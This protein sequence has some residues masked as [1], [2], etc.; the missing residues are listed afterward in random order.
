M[1]YVAFATD[2]DGTLATKGAVPE[3]AVDALE[4]L[5]ASDRHLFLVTGRQLEDLRKVFDRF[6]LFEWVVA[7]NGAVLF[8]PGTNEIRELGSAPPPEFAERLREQGV[9]PL[10]LGEVIVATWEPHQGTVLE[11][12]RELG[13]EL[14]IVFNKGAVMV[15]PPGVN[16][17]TGLHA[18]LEAAGISAH[19]VAG[20]GDAEND[21]AFLDLCECSVAVAN[22]LPSV[23]ERCDHVTEGDHADGVIEIARL[24]ADE[25]LATLEP[26]LRRHDVEL[27]KSDDDV[28]TVPAY[29]ATILLAGPSGSG[30]STLSTGLIERIHDAGYQ[31]CL[32]DPEGDYED[33]PG[34]VVL[35]DPDRVPSEDEV[36][37]VMQD[38]GTS[39]VL[40][41]L[42][43]RLED[44]PSYFDRLIPP[45]QQFR[46]RTG[47]P[48]WLV[49]DEAHHLLPQTRGAAALTLPLDLG[50]A[51]LVTI[52]PDHLAEEV[53]EQIDLVLATGDEPGAIL[54][55]LGEGSGDVPAPG[56]GHAVGQWRGEDP[57]AFKVIK[58]RQERRRHQRKYAEGELAE[59][60]SF[61]FRGPDDRLNL[62]AQ[63][64][65]LF[66]QIAEGVDDETWLHHLKQGDYS[67]WF[68]DK[69]KD[70]GLADDAE[71]VEAQEDPDPGETRTAIREIVERRYTLPE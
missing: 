50:A 35:G 54:A 57:F 9:D 52:H 3:K 28:L 56:K 58:P 10:S 45:L 60:R 5:R 25:D 31:F 23:K 21:L 8:H 39:L 43:V 63:N 19:N 44:R 30:K 4:H 11:V 41:L 18:A 69:I 2:Y 12:I 48:H 62:R 14:Q 22:A 71:K 38:P 46:A 20:I 36:E 61:Y 40:N 26:R 34:V 66:L 32:F 6:D 33:F 29:G 24:L 51:L 42:G 59:E 49:V 55:V 13:L 47:R 27:G 67:E 68:R 1:R 37:S 70:D 16:K 65:T 17:A 7:E 15:L 53:L 64:L